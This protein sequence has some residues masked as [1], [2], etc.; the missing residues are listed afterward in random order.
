[1]NQLLSTLIT[2]EQNAAV[3]LPISKARTLPRNAFVSSEFFALEV[4][5]IFAGRW[6]ALCFAEQL[7]NPG[8]VLPLEFAGKPVLAVRDRETIRVFHNIVPYDGCLAVIDPAQGVE[9]IRTPY[10]GWC[11]SLGGKLLR[12]PYWDGSPEPSV[13]VLTDNPGD[14]ISIRSHCA[15]GIVFVDF[16]GNAPEF[17]KQIS[18]FSNALIDYRLDELKIG[19]DKTGD[20]LID[21]EHIK[22]NWKTHFEN[23]AINVLHEGFTHDI[24]AEST[25]IPRVNSKREKTYRECLDGDFMALSYREADFAETYELDEMPLRSIGREAGLLPERACIGSFFPN[26]HF[27]VFPYFVHMIIVHPQSAG[28]THTLRAQFYDAASASD[29]ESLEERLELQAEFQQAGL[30]DSRV[31][32]A[33]QKARHSP[34]YEQHYYSPFWD[35][36]HHYFS[37]WLL[38]ALEQ[39]TTPLRDSI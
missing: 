16:S 34:V 3:R 36:M 2:P 33:V 4:E 6:V 17:T 32:E 27:A 38:D 15:M 24:Y 26:L 30:E 11:Y 29:P 28:Q 39:D 8:D 18:P 31:T 1:M 22:T 7:Q 13:A 5:K 19:Q 12:L 25:Q 21:Q 9:E 14:L 23:W 10:H 20:L 35:G 37:N